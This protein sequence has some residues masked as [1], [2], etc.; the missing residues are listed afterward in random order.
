MYKDSLEDTDIPFEI[1]QDTSAKNSPRIS[2][3]NSTLNVHYS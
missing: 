1:L 2:S 3:T